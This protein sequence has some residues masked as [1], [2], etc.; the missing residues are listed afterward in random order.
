MNAARTPRSGDELLVAE[1][2]SQMPLAIVNK[3]KECY[4]TNN[5]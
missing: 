2:W 1:V 5:G 3:Y 4:Q